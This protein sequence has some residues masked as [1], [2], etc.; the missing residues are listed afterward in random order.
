[1]TLHPTFNRH[2]DELIMREIFLFCLSVSSYGQI[3]GVAKPQHGLHMSSLDSLVL[4]SDYLHKDSVLE[5]LCNNISR[6]VI[7]NECDDWN[8]G[9]LCDLKHYMNL[10]KCWCYWPNNDSNLIMFPFHSGI[11]ICG[12]TMNAANLVCPQSEI[13]RAEISTRV[14][15]QCVKVRV[16]RKQRSAVN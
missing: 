3:L 15:A 1:M 11:L 7:M 6:S 14:S 8:C 12:Q 9:S 13:W 4:F 2:V 5:S 16:H 10:S